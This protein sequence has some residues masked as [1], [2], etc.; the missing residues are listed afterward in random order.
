MLRFLSHLLHDLESLTQTKGVL[1]KIEKCVHAVKN[2]TNLGDIF[3]DSANHQS[4]RAAFGDHDHAVGFQLIAKLALHDHTSRSFTIRVD[5]EGDRKLGFLFKTFGG[6]KQF[7]MVLEFHLPTDESGD[8]IL[9]NPTNAS[10]WKKIEFIPA[11]ALA[12]V[13][14][15]SKMAKRSIA[16]EK[17]AADRFMTAFEMIQNQNDEALTPPNQISHAPSATPNTPAVTTNAVKKPTVKKAPAKKK[18]S[19]TGTPSLS[20]T[21]VVNKID[22][23]I[24]A[25]NAH[26]ILSHIKNYA[27]AVQFSVMRGEKKKIQMDADTIWGAEIRNGETVV[28]D[29]FGPPPSDAFVKELAKK[30]NKYTQMDKVG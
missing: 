27:G 4:L 15:R 20:F 24:H 1:A 17:L 22:T 16:D 19:T 6:W 28:F 7:D 29:F 11:G 3:C 12:T 25:G 9:F 30:V 8:V 10:H 26:L 21:V 14:L 18:Y 2:G 23:F 13:H 5:I